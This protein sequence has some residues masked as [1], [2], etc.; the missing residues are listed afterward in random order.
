MQLAVLCS[1]PATLGKLEV[2]VPR[3]G[4][5]QDPDIHCTEKT[6]RVCEG[7]S[8]SPFLCLLQCVCPVNQDIVSDVV[9]PK[10]NTSVCRLP[11]CFS[12]PR[13]AST[14]SRGEEPALHWPSVPS[15][16]PWLSPWFQMSTASPVD[17]RHMWLDKR[18]TRGRDAA[19]TPDNRLDLRPHGSH[20]SDLGHITELTKLHFHLC[21]MGI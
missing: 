11:P 15:L 13:D 3:P 7:T 9:K 8:G 12:A 2:P 6:G 5:G 17:H 14:P 21:K 10:A 20:W 1:H 18:E 19:P 16:I 4:L